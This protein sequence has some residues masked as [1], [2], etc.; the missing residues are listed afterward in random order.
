[1]SDPK[2]HSKF[3]H[4]MENMPSTPTRRK[5]P[6]SDGAASPPSPFLVDGAGAVWSFGAET[7]HGGKVILKDGQ[8]VSG[9]GRQM[10]YRKNQMYLYNDSNRWFVWEDSKWLMS[11]APV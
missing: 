7:E 6:S 11:A 8:R 9:A 2:L 10:M 1:M 3:L 5:T 4:D